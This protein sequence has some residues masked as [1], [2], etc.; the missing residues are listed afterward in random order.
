MGG[1]NLAVAA[2]TL[3]R[4]RVSC[5][6]LP[7]WPPEQRPC[8]TKPLPDFQHWKANPRLKKSIQLM[9][10]GIPQRQG[11]KNRDESGSNRS[12]ITASLPVR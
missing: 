2:R 9:G 6:G 7:A 11:W 5:F 1:I 10:F 3:L 8:V 4:G 12:K